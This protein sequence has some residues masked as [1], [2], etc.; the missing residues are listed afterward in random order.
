MPE[1]GEGKVGEAMVEDA[2]RFVHGLL[3][4]MGLDPVIEILHHDGLPVVNAVCGADDSVA[5]GR[6]GKTLESIQ[7]LLGQVLRRRFGQA[8]LVSVDV[9]GYRERRRLNLISLARRSAERV[10]ETGLTLAEGPFSAYERH[11]IHAVLRDH[12]KVAT[13]S[14]GDGEQK[15]VAFRLRHPVIEAADARET[16]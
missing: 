1:T 2:A 6:Q 15:M 7:L 14:Q 8:S 3:R 12:P 11:I 4:H 16:R 5:I 10:Q 9:A 13:E